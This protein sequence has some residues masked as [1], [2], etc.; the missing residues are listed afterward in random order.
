MKMQ[1]ELRAPRDGRVT[2]VAVAA[3]QTIEVGDLLVVIE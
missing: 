1:N 2:M 3:D